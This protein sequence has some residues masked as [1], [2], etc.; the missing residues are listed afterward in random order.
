MA[1]ALG[2][3]AQC[4]SQGVGWSEGC[5]AVRSLC[6]PDL[7]DGIHRRVVWSMR[8]SLGQP[9]HSE[10]AAFNPDICAEMCKR[11]APLA[12]RAEGEAHGF[13]LCGACC[14]PA[15]GCGACHFL[16]AIPGAA[17]LHVMTLPANATRTRPP[18]PTRAL[19]P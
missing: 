17:C 14:C 8:S 5:D 16:P 4:R 10:L 3:W 13:P 1:V 11:A 19:H 6:L 7:A 9:K 12:S 15:V 18:S 2:G